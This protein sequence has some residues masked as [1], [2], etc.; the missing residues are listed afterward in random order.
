MLKNLGE[1]EILGKK[2]IITKVTK[3]TD[4]GYQK[5]LDQHF[6]KVEENNELEVFSRREK[7]KLL[8]SEQRREVKKSSH[9]FTTLKKEGKLTLQE[10]CNCGNHIRHNNGG[11]YHEIINLAYEMDT[12]L[13]GD[14]NFYIQ[15]SSTCELDPTPEWQEIS[16]VEVENLIADRLSSGY[17]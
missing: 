10:S 5:A 11:N 6:K 14:M 4:P 9:L 15:K 16:A 13:P 3:P 8:P 2:F 17:Y 12:E 7:M 1:L